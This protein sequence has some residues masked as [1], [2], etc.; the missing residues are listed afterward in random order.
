MTWKGSGGL[1]RQGTTMS[2]GSARAFS[3]L[4]SRQSSSPS[5]RGRRDRGAAL[6]VRADAFNSLS[7]RLENVWAALKDEDDLSAENI[8]APLK[9]IRRALL[10]ADVSLPV[11][12]RFIKSVEAKAVGVKVTKG[13]KASDQLTKV[14]ADE[15]C[16]LCLLYTSPS[17]RD[18][19]QSRMPSSA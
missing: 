13:V 1:K 8:K 3:S 6:V 11:V 15:L 14:V 5:T 18:K 10:E 19:R 17:P 7:N 4:R 2:G 9:D 16:E 12:R